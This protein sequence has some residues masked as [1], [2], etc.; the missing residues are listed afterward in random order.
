M[1]SGKTGYCPV[2]PD[3]GV[4][5]MKIMTPTMLVEWRSKDRLLKQVW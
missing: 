2:I 4:I 1:L 5:Y 3:N